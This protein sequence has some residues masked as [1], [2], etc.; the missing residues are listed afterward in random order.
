MS[1][2]T[3]L[4]FFL[5]HLWAAPCLG[6]II[7][8]KDNPDS[9][10]G[11]LISQNEQRVVVNEVLADGKTRQRVVQRSDIDLMI[12]SV[13][14]D[15][16][17]ALRPDQP[18]AYR[19]YADELSE[20]RE[21]PEARNAAIRLY[22]LAAH[23]DTKGQGRG[24]LLSMAGLARSPGEELKFRAIVYLL[25]PAHDRGVL[26]PPSLAK[27][28]QADLT[29]SERK[30]LLSAIRALRVGNR[31]EALNFSRR[32]LFQDVFKRYASVLSLEAFGAAATKRE[33][34]LPDAL[35]KKLI[36]LE[37]MVLNLPLKE[38]PSSGDVPWSMLV[39]TKKDSP[40][41]SLSLE[42]ITEFNP[43]ETVYKNKHWSVPK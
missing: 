20:K 4:L 34:L 43:N 38:K 36:T 26:K 30:M 35:V 11:F 15:R 10:K 2:W 33:A 3:L 5:L 13:G 9:I 29:P 42:T 25:D 41:E 6:V 31:R 27:A 39:T 24:A 18:R 21:D 7:L 28:P 1:R 37:M 32:P 14:E 17:M 19:D 8:R 22:L 23:L 40:V 16:L 12:I